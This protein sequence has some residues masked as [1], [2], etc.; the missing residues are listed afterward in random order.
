MAQTTMPETVKPV[1]YKPPPRWQVWAATGGALFLHL[2]AV[3]LAQKHEKPPPDLSDI[4]IAV[5]EATMEVQEQP[6]PPPEDVPLATP[7][8]EPQ[9]TPEFHEET[10]PPPKQPKQA[11]VA[12][13]KAPTV[14]RAGPMSISS[15]K[16]LA[17][18]APRPAY[19]YEAR[20]HRITGS[21]VCVVS[22]DPSGRVTDASMAVSLGNPSLDNS[23][24]S[25]FRQWRFKPGSVSKVRIPITFTMAGASY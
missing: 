5:V 13:I 24:T 3:A 11:K 10:T 23:A 2:I 14:G 1:L 16:A 22:V 17:T 8:P 6:T 20:S 15:A 9:E 4:P 19:P 25:T 21:G 18:Y 7:P 12:P